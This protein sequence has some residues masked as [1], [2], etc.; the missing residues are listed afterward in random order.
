MFNI[1]FWG[2]FCRTFRRT[3][4]WT[5]A[6]LA[7]VAQSRWQDLELIFLC[8]TQHGNRR[9]R[10][11]RVAFA[12]LRPAETFMPACMRPTEAACCRI[13]RFLRCAHTALLRV[14]HT[15]KTLCALCV[16]TQTVISVLFVHGNS[17]THSCLTGWC[18]LFY[19]D[20]RHLYIIVAN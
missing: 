18:N 10:G 4:T 6:C 16:Y 5:A 20:G 3:A 8:L 2:C 1:I 11:E 15:R 12:S 17:N 19:F 7:I 13:Q 14:I 9:A